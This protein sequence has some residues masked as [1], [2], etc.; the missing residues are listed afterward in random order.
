MIHSLLTTPVTAGTSSDSATPQDWTRTSLPS[1]RMYCTLSTSQCTILSP[2]QVHQVLRLT[3]LL[4]KRIFLD[5]LAFPSSAP[6]ST[7]DTLLVQS[8][9]L[10]STSDDLVAALYTPQDLAYVYKEILQLAEI[11]TSLQ[12]QISVLLPVTDELENQLHTLSVDDG[13]PVATSSSPPKKKADKKW[14]DTCVDQ[15][16]RLCVSLS[17]SSSQTD[18]PDSAT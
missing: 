5:L 16:V 14:F 4:H 11:A 12:T 18:K 6:V 17:E 15:I 2:P 10:L 1:Q 7:F 3:T 13:N 8:N 9:L